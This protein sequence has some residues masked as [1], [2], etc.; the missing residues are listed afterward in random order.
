MRTRH[1]QHGARRR[2]YAPW[3]V[4][5]RC[6]LKAWPCYVVRMQERQR[7]MQPVPHR[8][9]SDWASRTSSTVRLPRTSMPPARPLLTPG[10]AHRSA[11]RTR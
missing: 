10:Q 2:W 1:S 3:T 6:G 4:I 11:G 9:A 5:C 7:G 8:P